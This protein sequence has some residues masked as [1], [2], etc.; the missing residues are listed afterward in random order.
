MSLENIILTNIILTAN[1]TIGGVIDTWCQMVWHLIVDAGPHTYS[2]C[3]M[4]P[5]M[6]PVGV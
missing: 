4:L 6:A 2:V 3:K 1:D 5:Q